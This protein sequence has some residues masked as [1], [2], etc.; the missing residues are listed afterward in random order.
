MEITLEN[1]GIVK[2]ATIKLNGLTL[3]AG[4]NDSGKS[5]VGKSLFAVLK[6]SEKSRGEKF[7]SVRRQY[8]L[9]KVDEFKVVV[10]YVLDKESYEKIVKYID[11]LKVRINDI[12]TTRRL[13]EETKREAII[14]QL[15]S[16]ENIVNRYP[17]L[18][19]FYSTFRKDVFETM[20]DFFREEFRKINFQSIINSL[21]DRDICNKE[22]PKSKITLT[23]ANKI[24]MAGIHNNKVT[25]FRDGGINFE[26]V[27]YI[28]SP[29]IL[30]L[31][32]L[33]SEDEVA[34]KD[35]LPTAKDLK[36][37]IIGLPRNIEDK[38]DSARFI[39][40]MM[41]KVEGI[42]GGEVGEKAGRIEF[43]K[44]GHIY[45]VKNISDGIKSF[46][47]LLL[48]LKKNILLKNTILIIEEPEVFLHPTWQLNYAKVIMEF[49]KNGITVLLN[50]HSPYMI[51]AIKNYVI[52]YNLE[53]KFDVYFTKN[54][55]IKKIDDSNEKTFEKIFAT[56]AEP[57]NEIEKL[58]KEVEEKQGIKKR[59]IDDE[60]DDLDDVF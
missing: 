19:K 7:Y 32:D 14:N 40:K 54:G 23:H 60:D 48:L 17:N 44:D 15:N 58:E 8:L 18:T 9:K 38:L 28:D 34:S 10:S 11:D 29:V 35:Y 49:V 1:I 45:S 16:F 39:E 55:I 50:S 33:L 37:K 5:T 4:T 27:T 20:S 26:D 2:N 24:T 22:N 3:L 59:K 47:L 36:Q 31:I 56:L 53:E 25:F 30:Q 42:I 13:N 12:L 51:E 43:E 6:A 21:F 52:L 46:I 41:R 57:F